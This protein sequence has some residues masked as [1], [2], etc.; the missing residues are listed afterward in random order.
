MAI[1]KENANLAKVGFFEFLEEIEA[2]QFLWSDIEVDAKKMNVSEIKAPINLNFFIGY[3][4]RLKTTSSYFYSEPKEPLYYQSYYEKLG[5]RLCKTWD[6]F[7]VDMKK[8][9]KN[10]TAI[11]KKKRPENK[12]TIRNIDLKNFKN[13]MKL[14][15]ELFIATYKKMPE[16]EFISFDTF[17][18][19]YENFKYLIHPYFSYLVFDGEKAVGFCINFIDP[20]EKILDYQK[21]KNPS[22]L[23]KL[24]LL[25]KLKCN[26][27][28]LLIIYVGRFDD[29]KY[30]GVQSLVSKRLG[31]MALIFG[32]KEALV[33]FTSEDSPAKK[34]FNM[35]DHKIISQYG[36]FKKS[37]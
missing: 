12:L 1:N 23:D 29:E 35:N 9:R 37:I 33:C 32:V 30:K 10:F 25:L 7:Q 21:K 13:D 24:I 15:Y 18:I 31:I 26:F 4:L 6:S 16:Y 2:L 20:L 19:L 11:R 27:K 3:R 36:L 22:K 5:L 8:T 34:S 17:F 14:V 28:R